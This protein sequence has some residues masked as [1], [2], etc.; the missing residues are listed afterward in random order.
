MSARTGRAVSLAVIT[1]QPLPFLRVVLSASPREQ[2]DRDP[3]LV[4]KEEE[5]EEPSDYRLEGGEEVGLNM[6]SRCWLD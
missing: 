4:Y 1:I 2:Q 3:E 5:E 6:R